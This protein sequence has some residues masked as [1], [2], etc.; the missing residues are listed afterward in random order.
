LGRYKTAPRG[1][2]VAL[3]EKERCSAIIR[4]ALDAIA[5][6]IDGKP[7]AATTIARKRAVI[8]GALSYAV[9]LDLL[10]INPLTR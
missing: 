3:D 7:A 6:I 2:P 1:R 8:Y 4:R 10:A 5:L 9:E